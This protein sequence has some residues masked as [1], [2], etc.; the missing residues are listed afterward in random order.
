[1]FMEHY[2]GLITLNQHLLNVLQCD[3]YSAINTGLKTLAPTDLQFV[4]LKT[5]Y[6]LKAKMEGMGFIPWWFNILLIAST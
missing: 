6:H 4:F 5:S 1:M 3:R 2:L